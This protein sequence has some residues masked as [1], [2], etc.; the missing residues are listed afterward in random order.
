MTHAKKGW[1]YSAGERGR[2]RV[3]AFAHPATGR[4]FLELYE[5][6][7][8]K[9]FAL[10][11][12]DREV[13]KQKAEELATALRRAQFVPVTAPTLQTLFDIYEVEVTPHKG[14]SKQE[15]DRRAMKCF[16]ELFGPN[17]KVGTLSRRDW[18][19]FIR[20][21]MDGGDRRR[22]RSKGR[23]VRARA[24]EY[25]LKFL[26][27]VLNWATTAR[28][29]RGG[30]L[31]ERNPLKGMPWPRELSPRR[32][33]LFDE[34]YQALLGV[35]RTISPLFE[36]ALIL[37]HESGHRI[38]SIRLLRW[39]D[40][41]WS[42][43]TV[44]W[45]GENDKIRFEHETPLTETA[46]DALERARTERPSIG[47]AWIFPAPGDPS[48]PC[49]R[50][51]MRDWW[52]RAEEA[53]KLERV[54]G[55]G[56]HSL[57]RK[58]ATELKHAPL[59]DLSYLGG[60]KEPQTVVKCYQRPDESTMRGALAT[61]GKLQRDGDVALNRHHESTPSAPSDRKVNPA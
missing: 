31:V 43:G 8:R 3:R 7:R 42:R 58:F 56:W 44:R 40:V 16:V 21:R 17:R 15:H 52:Q 45:R 32:P 11:T 61:R 46:L 12:C 54:P 59:S 9:R 48:Q 28:D 27:A 5:D 2:N 53:A 13:A 1:S 60:W 39:S 30:V 36:L 35:S 55:R 23:P 19:A 29:A 4:L 51:L 41:Y 34:E 49:S 25:D 6:G 38:N 26:Q 14:R 22:G 24:V 37:A 50:H 47:D 10:G 20:W 18:D 57:R 33:T